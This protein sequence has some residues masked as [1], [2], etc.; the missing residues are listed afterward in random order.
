MRLAAALEALPPGEA[1]RLV[2]R[3]TRCLDPMAVLSAVLDAL[4]D[5]ATADTCAAALGR[6]MPCRCRQATRGSD[7]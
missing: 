1:L 2:K 6:R 5:E 4:P 3:A 7:T